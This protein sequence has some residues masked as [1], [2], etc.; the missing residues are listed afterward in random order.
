MKLE[1]A[2]KLNKGD[3]VRLEG[4]DAILEVYYV[5]TLDPNLPIMVMLKQSSKELVSYVDADG[6]VEEIGTSAEWI[7]TNREV[8]KD[9]G[10]TDEEIEEALGHR[11]LVCVEDLEKVEE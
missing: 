3:L 9:E 4:T 8:M 6:D 11:Y 7:Y 5:D 1:E 2:R 10:Q